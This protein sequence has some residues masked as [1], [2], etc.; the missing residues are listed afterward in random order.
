MLEKRQVEQEV[1]TTEEDVLNLR[2]EI[3]SVSQRGSGASSS[4]SIDADTITVNNED[5]YIQITN[6][7]DQSAEQGFTWSLL[8]G[9][10]YQNLSW[11]TGVA[12]IEGEDTP[13]VVAFRSVAGEDSS[14]ITYRVEFR[15]LCSESSGEVSKVDIESDGQTRA[16]GSTEITFTNDGEEVSNTVIPDGACEGR[17]TRTSTQIGIQLG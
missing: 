14:E 16:S 11:T 10:G 4:V 9:Q 7:L 5:E 1:T 12:A 3:E 6:Q 8:D 17:T 2:E 15:N 13:G